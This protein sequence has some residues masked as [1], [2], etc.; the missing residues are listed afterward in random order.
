MKMD[1]K[2]KENEIRLLIGLRERCENFNEFG[3]IRP[4]PIVE[5]LGV[6]FESFSRSATYLQG[7]KLTLIDF[8]V[9]KDCDG[10]S[11]MFNGIA[12]TSEG[13]NYLRV[14]EDSPGIAKKLTLSTLDI[15]KDGVL[16]VASSLLTEWVKDFLRLRP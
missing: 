2:I 16:Q 5:L 3:L 14:L 15:V 6:S 12:L 8:H 7:F 10:Y 1:I 11:K 4:E 9:Q 13:E